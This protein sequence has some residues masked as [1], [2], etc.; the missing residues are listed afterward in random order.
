MRRRQTILAMVLVL[1]AWSA[2]SAQQGQPRP[3]PGTGIVSVEGTVNV[4]NLPVVNA[5]GM[6]AL[7]SAQ[8]GDWK[9]TVTSMPPVTLASM[10]FVRPGSRYVVTW[11]AET[12]TVSV[13]SMGPGAWIRVS[14]KTDRWVNLAMARS[15][16][17][18]P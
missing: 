10:P 4:A 5:G 17:A 14:G 9:A 11:A 15:V 6:A 12:E 1:V 16:E 3:G 18:A 2:T 7:P 13:V 8:V